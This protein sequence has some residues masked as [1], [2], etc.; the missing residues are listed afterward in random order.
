[1]RNGLVEGG[2]NVEILGLWVGCGLVVVM[3]E[4]IIMMGPFGGLWLLMWGDA[5]C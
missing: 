3:V 4:N 1:M 5:W 2:V